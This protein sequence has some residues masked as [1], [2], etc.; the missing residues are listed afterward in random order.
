[1]GFYLYANDMMAFLNLF[2][3]T[4]EEVGCKTQS[5]RNGRELTTVNVSISLFRSLYY[6]T[7][8]KQC[9]MLIETKTGLTG[10]K[11]VFVGQAELWIT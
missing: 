6:I 3:M 9:F 5:I 8:T 10:Q 11:P 4:Q 2:L 1:M 7:E